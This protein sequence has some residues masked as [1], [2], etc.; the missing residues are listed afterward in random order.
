MIVL[1]TF[2]EIVDTNRYRCQKSFERIKMTIIKQG[3]SGPEMASVFPKIGTKIHKVVCCDE[4]GT[5]AEEM[6]EVFSGLKQ[7]QLTAV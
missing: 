6:I 2:K 3:F 1:Y 7:L 5:T 4:I